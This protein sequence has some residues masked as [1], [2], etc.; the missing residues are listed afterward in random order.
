MHLTGQ[1][2]RRWCLRRIL[3]GLSGASLLR[4][5]SLS[6]LTWD[7]ALP[8]RAGGGQT[9][10]AERRYRAEAHV[11][12][13]GI[14]LF[15]RADV[16]G[17]S[18]V[19]RESPLTQGGTLR[20]LEFTGFSLPDRAAGLNRIGF[21]REMAR[22][23]ES[24]ATESIYFGLMTSSPEE[25][26]EEAR[27]AIESHSAEAVYSAIEG[28]VA[29]GEVESVLA[30]FS[31]P[32]KWTIR[33]QDELIEVAHK[34]LAETPKTPLE[35]NSRAAGES[36]FLQ[37]LA[38]LLRESFSSGGA[39]QQTS[40]IY[41]GHRYRL[42]LRRATDAKAT[43]QYRKRGA[44]GQGS[45]VLRA[46]GQVRREAGGKEHN[47]RLWFDPG[48]EMPIPLRIEYQAKSYLHLVFDAEA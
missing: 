27:K 26:A 24:G 25:S 31:A 40:Y 48:A 38:R 17:G 9:R 7:A 37:S 22:L 43:G 19:W 8:A 35:A 13:L 3:Y 29:A 18:A 23:G 10:A 30:H 44:I 33:N 34:A 2:S 36:T 5:A 21:I 39:E 15:H 28:R 6:E 20:F 42:S 41:N 32:A 46:S 47:F 11:I 4:A 1:F 16:G 45:E 14:T 12:V